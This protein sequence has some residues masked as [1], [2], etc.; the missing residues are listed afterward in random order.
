MLPKDVKLVRNAVA[1][2]RMAAIELRRL[3]ARDPTISAEL[4]VI[5]EKLDKEADELS[6]IDE[7]P[8]PGADGGTQTDAAPP[9]LLRQE[10]R[11]PRPDN[12]EG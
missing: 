3:A 2:H 9:P 6:Q 1:F 12:S 4:L 5:A 7:T 8:R 10:Q 11:V